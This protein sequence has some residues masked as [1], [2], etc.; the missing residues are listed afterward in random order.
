MSVSDLTYPGNAASQPR[1]LPSPLAGVDLWWCEVAADDA[2]QTLLHA[3]LSHD[4]RAR[5]LRFGR[6]S[7]ATRYIVGRANLRWVLSRRL[8]CTPAAVPIV[9]DRT[10][11]PRLAGEDLTDFNV[12]NTLGVALIGVTATPGLR[13]GV[14][15]E[16][17]ERRVN[18]T[19]LA[20]KFLTGHERQNLA[21][22]DE[23]TRRHAFLRLW[24]CKEAMS[25]AT[26]DALSAPLRE[27][28]VA[29]S[30][31]LQLL[32]GPPPYVADAWELAAIAVPHGY[33]ATLALWRQIRPGAV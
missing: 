18:H 25:K 27:L 4:E 28:D 26:G 7:L 6:A 23:P 14:D 13:I 24:T 31:M 30:P 19:A 21:G 5:A 22:L 1:P 10:G 15:L 29:L 33:L 16:H 8:G 12:S 17:A 20:R 32:G 3:W 2:A 9:R 11:R